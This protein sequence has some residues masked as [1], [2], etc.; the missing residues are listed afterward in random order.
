MKE[1]RS[2]QMSWIDD[3]QSAGDHATRV[4]GDLPYFSQ[5]LKIRPKVGSL[6]PFTLNAAQLKLHELIEDQRRRTGRV[7]VIVL[8]AR[9]LGVSTYVAS[10]FYHKTVSAPGL[11]T[12]IVAHK[13]D[14]SRNC[15]RSLSAFTITCLT[16]CGPR[17]RCPTPKS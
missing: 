17:S 9:Q 8:K 3:L 15:S 5:Y 12:I 10:R 13:V 16:T 14:A 7:R 1:A 4:K 6:A 11:R 2:T